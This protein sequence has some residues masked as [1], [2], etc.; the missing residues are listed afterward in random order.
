MMVYAVDHPVGYPSVTEAR[1]FGV[2]PLTGPRAAAHLSMR[3][4]DVFCCCLEFGAA[5][6]PD[7]RSVGYI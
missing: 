4:R 7:C 1:F 5:Q 3:E 2:D 6:R